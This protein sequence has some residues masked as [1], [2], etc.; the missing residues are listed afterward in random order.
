MII[1]Q[2]VAT[3]YVVEQQAMFREYFKKNLPEPHNTDQHVAAILECLTSGKL[4]AWALQRPQSKDA[5]KLLGFCTT[6]IVDDML[7]GER[8]LWIYS[9]N[10][11][12]LITDEEWQSAFERVEAFGR[13]HGCVKTMCR[14]TQDTVRRLA[15]RRGMTQKWVYLEKDLPNVESVQEAPTA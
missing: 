2:L 6:W 7:M 9:V 1:T 15:E 12:G 4:Q 13:I 10:S 11:N 8:V 14:T 5:P 3:P